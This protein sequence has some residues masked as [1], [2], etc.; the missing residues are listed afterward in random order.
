MKSGLVVLA[1]FFLL[2][3]ASASMSSYISESPEPFAETAPAPAEAPQGDIVSQPAMNV[4]SK[5]HD[6]GKR[7]PR[8]SSL[9][10]TKREVR[11]CLTRRRAMGYRHLHLN[12]I[13]QKHLKKHKRYQALPRRFKAQKYGD[14]KESS[15]KWHGNGSREGKKATTSSKKERHAY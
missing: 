8:C 5:I 12:S 9:F 4:P 11:K 10:K 14:H 7:M 1:L 2:G 6:Q 13:E 3:V 15:S